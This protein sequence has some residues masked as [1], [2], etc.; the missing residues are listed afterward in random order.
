MDIQVIIRRC[1]ENN[2]QAQEE[3]YK[4]FFPVMM[5]LCMRYVRDRNDALELLND[6]FLKVFKQLAAYDASKASLYT[7]IRKIVINTAIDC[8]RR[9]DRAR[10][11]EILP[12]DEGGPRIDNEAISKMSGDELLKL[13]LRLPTTT[14][15]V[16]NLFSVEGFAHR[17]IA[18]MLEISE[19][20]SRWHLSEARR[21]LKLIMH[22]IETNT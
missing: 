4:R 14:R 22:I 8:L 20:T 21:Q 1:L 11:Q 7:W 10:E 9:Q 6:A 17:E 13:L 16:F 2:R 12:V 5:P 19:G 15:L 3:L 18:A